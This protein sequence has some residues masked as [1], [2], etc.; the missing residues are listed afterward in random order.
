VNYGSDQHFS[1]APN[2]GYHVDS[3]IVDGVKV[4]SDTQYTFTNVTAAHTIRVTFAINT[5]TITSSAGLNGA[6]SPT[7][8]VNV[9]YGSDQHFSIAP[10]TGYH[11]D[12]LIVDG[13]KVTSDT[14]YTFTNVTAVNTIRVT[15]AINTF[16]ITSSAGANG[17]I[18]PTP[19][20][21]VNFGGSQHFSIAPNTGYHVDSLIVDG[22]KIAPD[23][24]YTFTNVTVSHTIRATFAINTFTIA[25][26]AGLNG[27]IL[28]TPSATVIYGLSQHFS[29]A[30]NT[31]YHM[32]SLI[33]DGVKVTSDTGYT[34]TNVTAVHT[35]RVTFAINTFIIT[36]SAGANG[37]ISPT[38]SATVNYGSD[39]HFSITPNTGYH[40][41]SLIMDGTKIASDT[42]YTFTNVTAAHTIR[43]AFV[44]DTF[45]IAS[46]AG[47]NGSISPTPSIR[48]TYGATQ[49]FSIAP[50]TG[51]HVDSLIIDGTPIAADTQYT[52]SS[53]AANHSIHA[54]F[55]INQFT[56]TATS[57]ANGVISPSGAVI[58]NYNLSQHFS[59][60]PN[61]GYHIDSLIVDGVN[62]N[63]DT[64]YT[65]KNVTASHTIRVTFAINTYTVT[66]TVT[67]GGT[68][69][70]S[71]TVSIA[72][73]ASQTF[74]FAANTGYYIV[75]VLYDG[76]SQGPLD[77]LKLTN[78]TAN[79][80]IHAAFAINQFTITA[81][82]AANGVISP[83]G[84]VIVNYNLSQHFS[85]V[86]NTGY[87][88][89]SLIID[90]TPVAADTQYTF[91]SVQTNHTIHAAF[92]INQFTI[93]AAAG[94]NGVVSPA[95]AVIVN[96]NLSQHFSIAP[97]TGY[98]VDS[99]IVDGV[100]ITSDTQYTF[101]NVNASH[102]IRVTFA[103]NTYSI[104][105]SAGANGTIS[106]TPSVTV[107]YGGSQHF[108]IA[109]NTG[110]HVD[111]LIVNGGKI[112]SDTQYTFTNVT[113]PHAIRATFA[114]NTFTIT[115]SAGADGT[116]SPTPSVIVNY[117]GS[118]HFSIV[119]NT[120]YHVDSLIVD[121]VKV[122][123]DTQYTFNSVISNHTINVVFAIDFNLLTPI[124]LAPPNGSTDQPVSPTLTWNT[125]RL[126][127][128]Y[129]LQVATDTGFTQRVIPDDT[130]LTD[131]F[132]NVTGLLNST[133]Y[134]WRVRA[135]HVGGWSD[136]SAR[137]DFSTI[138]A[139]PGAPSLL[140]PTN[141]AVN[142]PVSPT[143]I[144]NAA[145]TAIVYY[146]QLATD[147]GFTQRVIPDD[148]TL[149]DTFK[150]VSGLLNNT[151]YYWR[152]RAK[153]IGGWSNWSNRWGFTTIIAAPLAPIL[154]TPPNGSANQPVSPTLFWNTSNTAAN[155]DLQ[156]ATDAGF[157]QR[158]IPDDTTLT[159]T[160]KSISGL[161]NS[162]QYYW[163]VR[164]KNIGGWSN[165]SDTWSF[166]TIIAA[167]GAPLLVAPANSA[168]NQPTSAMFQWNHSSTALSY[169]LQVATDTGFTQRVI[170]DDTTLT[171]TLKSVDGL[172]NSTTY[173]WRV[174]AK[175]I[176][177]WSNWSNRWSFTTI[178][179]A[180][181]VPVL[182]APLSNSVNQPTSMTF[183][184]NILAT[185]LSYDLQVATDTGFTLKVIPDDTTLADTFRNVT[186]LLNSTQYYWRVR[187][188]NIGGWSG[189]S[190]RWSFTTIIAAPIAPVLAA[191]SNGSTNLPVPPVFSWNISNNATNYDLQ[192]AT[193]TGFTQRVIPD[194]TTLTDS[195]KNVAGLLNSTTYYWRVR[196]KNVGGWSG[197]SNRWSFTTIIAEPIAPVLAAPLNGSTNQ[198]VSPALFWNI[199]ATATNYDLQLA[200][201]TGFT[202]KVIP[203]DTTLTD[204][205][206]NVTGLLNST[207]YYWRVRAKN[208]GGWSSWSAR[209]S[210]TTII[211]APLAP[212][213]ASPLNGSANQPVSP[214]L[215]WNISNTAT[216]YDLQLATDTGFTQRVIPDDTTLT[217]T[218]KNVAGLLN[219]TT[220]YW[221]VRAKNAGGWSGW[222]NRWSFTTIIAA[223][224]A[225]VLV[226]P[227]N[228]SSNEPV[229]SALFWNTSN[230]ATNYDLQVA[231]DTG[232][233]QKVI[234]DDTTLADTFKNVTGLLNST[235]YYWRV[236]AKN[237]G[238]WSNW[239]NTWSFTTIIAAP[240][241]PLLAAP[242][243]GSADQP[244]SPT[245]SWNISNTA[246][247][248]ELQAA[249][250]T[251]F[252]QK[253]ISDDTTLTDTFKNIA[254][255]LNSTTYYWRVRAKNV[256]GWSGWSNRWSFTTVIA[257]PAAP[258]LLAP[259][260]GSVSWPVSP[261][262]IWNASKTT[263]AYYYQLATD[264]G[265]TQRVIPDDT[266]LTDTFKNVAGLLNNTTYYWRV[267]A[268][269]I[270]GWSNWSGRWGFTT[271]IV[272]PIAPAL[273][274]PANG[275][276]N[277]PVS[278]ELFWIIS[279]T[280]TNYDLQIATDT[281]FTQRVVPDDTTLTDTVKNITGLLNS[282][283]YYWRVR[284][285]NIGGWSN[286]SERWSF[287]TVVGAPAPP[288]L[289]VPSNNSTDQPTSIA[290]TWKHSA[291]SLS[292]ELQVATDT[293][294]TQKVIPDDTTLVDTVKNV[295]GL[296]NNTTYH[297]RVRSKNLG[298]WSNWSERWSFTTIVAAP[299]V[300]VLAA[301]L[302]NS[303]N[304]PTS[305]SL[306]W[307]VLST[308]LSYDLQLATDTGFTQKVI[309]DD[310]TLT[311]TFKNV[312]GLLNS[313]QYYWRV[314]AKNVGG[315]S[316]W[317]NRWSFT[318]IIAV[319]ITPVLAAPLNGSTNQP[320]SPRLAWNTSSTATNY[321]LQVAT[322][323]GF[324]Q[325]VIPDDTT[326]T[327][328]FKNISGLL[329][330]T[331]Y[332]WRVRAK[333]VGGWSNWSNRWSFTTI[334]AAPTSPVLAAPLNGSTNQPL[335]PVLFWN[336]SNTAAN[337]DL[338][339]AAD[340]GF[341]QKVIPDDTTLTDTFKNVTGLL[342]ST[343]Y[344]WR[345]RAKNVGGWSNWSNRWSF[346]TIIA[347]PIAPLLVTPANGATNQ[348]VSPALLWNT[349]GTAANYDLQVATDTGF[350]Q[351]VIPDDTTLTDTFKNVTGLLNSTT[352]Y[353]RVRAKNV[354]GWSN[355]SNRWSFATIITAPIA[356]LLVTPANGA[357][358]QPVSPILFWNTSI[359][360]TNYDLQ[361][362]ADTGFVQKVIP[363]DTTLTDTS[364]F[365]VGLL[366]NSTYYWR[367]RAKTIGGW[368]GWSSRWSF[369]TIIAPPIAPLLVTPAN[370]ATNEPVSLTLFWNTSGT[371][372]NY[373]L[374]LATDTGFTQKVI[375]D[376]TTLTDTFKNVNGLLN[377]TT[378]YWR[379]R[380]K[381]VGGW[382]NWSNRR[383]FTTIMT[384]PIAPV[385]A[386]PLNGAINQPVS[387]VVLWNTSNSATNYDL[388]LA[389]DTG[390]TQR[391][392]PDDTTLTDTVKNVTGLLNS[393]T[394]YWRVRAKNAGGWSNWSARWSFT[395]IIAAPIAPILVTP[396][397]GSTNQPVS[398]MLFWNTSSMATNYDLQIATDTGF[399]QR[400]VPDDTTLTDTFKN[401][402]GLL[403]STTYYWRV[404]AKNAGGWSNWSAR[405]SF[406]T[407]I[408]VPPTSVLITP[409]TNSIDQ[410]TSMIFQWNHAFS[411]L[412][413]D[414]Q[415]ATDTGF[416]QKVIPDDTTLADTVKSVDGLLNNTTYYWRVR[417]KNAG[418]WSNWSARWSFTT[419]IAAP[420]VP[421]LVAPLSNS[422]NQPTS[423][424]FRWNI[425]ATAL[426][427]DLQVATDT[428]FTQKVIPDDTTLTDTFKNISGLLNSTQ[429]YWRVRAKNIGGWSGWSNRWSFT[430]II[431][432]PAAPIL[433]TPLNGSP[434][435]TLSPAL[436]WNTSATATNYELQAA[437][438]T[439]FTQKV[440][441]DDTTLTDTSKS[442]TGLL[443]GTTY[444][445][446][447]RAKN[448]GGWSNWSTRWSF[449]T[450]IAAPA[451][452]I[453]VTPLNGSTN[454]PV[455]PTLFW[456][457]SSI[458][459]NYDLQ[460]AT[461]TGFTQR[462]IPDDTTLADTFKNIAGLL[463]STTYYWRVRA[464]NAGGWSD[465]SARW[466]FTTIIAVPTVPVL[467]APLNNSVD[468]PASITFKWNIL[469]TALSYDLQVATD[470][471]FTQK[472]ITDDTTLA[473]TFKNVSGLFNS[474][475]YYWRVRAKNAG[476][477][478]N[479]SNR[480]SFTTIIAAPAAPIL[481]APLNGSLN[482]P[483]SPALIWNTTSTATNYE[484]QA[485]TDTGF[486]QKIIP[487]DTTLTDT[488][489]NVTGLLNSTQ[490]YWRVRAKNIGGW[491]NWSA[492]W[493]FAT[494]I[495][496]PIAPLLMLPPNGSVNQ[497]VSP[498]LFWNTASTATNYDL[499]V[500]TDTGFAQKVVPDDTTMTDTFKN[501]TGLLNSTTYYWRV[502]SKNI[503]GWSGWSTVWNFTTI[504]AAPAAPLLV[505]P[506]NGSLNEPVSPVL[507]WNTSNT[508]T[509]YDLQVATDPGFAQKIIPDDTSLTDTFK[510]VTGLLNSTQYYWR[511]RAKN[512]GGW[513]GWSSVWSF[514]TIIAA[515][516]APVLVTPLNVSVNQP[517]SP[518]LFWNISNTAT[519]YDLQI[520]TDTGFTQRVIPDDT[521][522]TDTFKNVTGLLN[523][524]T[525]YWRVRAK[526]I[527][528][529]SNWT[530][531]WSFTTIIAAPSVPLLIEPANAAVNQPSSSI[532]RWSR[533]ETAVFYHLQIATD[534]GFTQTV[535][536][537]DTTYADTVENIDGLANNTLYY[538]RV[539]AKNIGG[540]SS[541]SNRSSFTTIIAAPTVPVLISPVSNSINQPLD[542]VLTW[543]SLFSTT[544]YELQVATDTGF[545][546]MI[547]PVD[548][549]LT[550]TVKSIGGLLNST[551]YYWRVRAKNI[552]G[553]SN[554]SNRWSFKTIIA[555]PSAPVLA[556]PS[557]GLNEQSLALKL[558]WNTSARAAD[559]LL[560]VATD[561]SFTQKAIPDDTTLTDT[562]KNVSGLSTSTMYYWRVR[563]RN[564][565]GWSDWSDVW[566]FTTITPRL[567][568]TKSV[569]RDTIL[570]GDTLSYT[571]RFK[572]IGKIDF[573][574]FAVVDTLPPDFINIQASSNA[575]VNGLVVHYVPQSLSA[576]GEDSI[577]IIATVP[578][579]GLVSETIVNKVTATSNE[580]GPQIAQAVS[581][582]KIIKH[583]VL[584]FSLATSK[585]TVVAGDTLRYAIRFGNSGNINL[586]NVVIADNIPSQFAILGITGGNDTLKSNPV[587]YTIDSLRLGQKDSIVILVR[588][589][590]NLPNRMR[591]ADTASAF[592]AETQNARVE[593][594]TI[595]KV[596]VPN[597][598]CRMIVQS[599]SNKVVGNGTASAVITVAVEDTLGT[600]KPDGT[601]VLLSTTLG[602]FSNGK[603]TINLP[604][605]GGFVKDSLKVMLRAN[606]ID[607]A[608]ITISS[609][610]SDVCYTSYVEHVIFFPGAIYGVVTDN[611]TGHAVRGASVR[612][613]SST[614]ALIDSITT[615]DDGS[616]M[617]P[618]PRTDDYQVTVKTTNIFGQII[619]EV[620]SIHVD[621]PDIG[622]AQP[623]PNDNSISGTLFSSILNV[624]IPAS[625]AEVIL[626]K[627]VGKSPGSIADSTMADS[628][629]RY[630]FRHIEP[631]N[632]TLQLHHPY[633]QGNLSVQN[634]RTGQTVTG[635]DI[636]CTWL[637][638]LQFTING[639]NLAF[640]TDTVGFTIAIQ[641]NAQ[642]NLTNV[643]VVDTLDPMMVFVSASDNGIYDAA[644]HRILWNFNSVDSLNQKNLLVQVSFVNTI[645]GAALVRSR[646]TVR[647]DQSSP[648]SVK[649]TTEVW[650][651]T[652]PEL[653]VP[654][655]NAVGQA[656]HVLFGW[657]AS[658]GATKYHLKIMQNSGAV[659][660][661]D[662]TITATSVSVDLDSP[663]VYQWWV[664]A[665]NSFGEGHPSQTYTFS[666]GKATLRMQSPIV[667]PAT[668]ELTTD[669]RLFSMPGLVDGIK[670][671]SVLSGSAGMDWR[672]F[673]DNGADAN[674]FVQLG[675]NST[676]AHGEG[677][678]L[679]KDGNLDL[680]IATLMPALD[681]DG[682]YSIPLHSGWNI[683]GNPYEKPALW[684]DILQANSL[685]PNTKLFMYVG[686][687]EDTTTVL[688]PFTGYY[689]SNDL[690]LSALTIPYP[691]TPLVVR[692]S[693]QK[694]DWKI[695]LL[696]QSKLNK[697][698]A[699][700]IGIAPDMSSPNGTINSRKPP[701]FPDQGMLYFNGID[702]AGKSRKYSTDFRPS[703]DEGQVWNFE[704]VN[705]QLS[706]SKI[707]FKGLDQVPAEYSVV[708]VNMLN[709]KPIDLRTAPAYAYKTVAAKM[710]FALI[711]GKPSFVEKEL[712][713][714]SPKEFSLA[715]NYPNPFNPATSISFSLP[716]K[717]AVKMEIIDILG[718]R[719][720][721]L[722]EGSY[723]AG[724]YTVVWDG[725]NASGKQASSGVYFYRMLVDNQMLQTRKMILLK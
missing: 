82:A 591:I 361:I 344:Y 693:T 258:S 272:P 652:F 330:S 30:P 68:I 725:K 137:W 111:S 15:F 420:S 19:S 61:T 497:P 391:V 477:W 265:F 448:A 684:S 116:I 666:V 685:N 112:T 62:I 576:G 51:Y 76:N 579:T 544:S 42:Q 682:N 468:Q 97:I 218:F 606:A 269:N 695:Q 191:P 648:I 715:Q 52:F 371:A 16:I 716:R 166:T 281:G 588:V 372:T 175:N 665:R 263:I 357:T 460:L 454:Q 260:N 181:S 458:A 109:A 332:Y 188:K 615:G 409:L 94:A 236:R 578:V 595:I 301:P 3:L 545:V 252:T 673:R 8:G 594:A 110:Y 462:V 538:W 40:V 153:N 655:N 223:P 389:T 279:S 690:N 9:N 333:N 308:A 620:S 81:T 17:T 621:I 163:R 498:A 509:N 487:D 526:N 407:I 274:T 442:I 625:S 119:P 589:P 467:S 556:A 241:A 599:S 519:N 493:S 310:T 325:R 723:E 575:Q 326:L 478:S 206:K 127:V 312:A 572:N 264:T 491:S 284:A 169:Y 574:N 524:T 378:Y 143:F 7:P 469:A 327:D 616:Y 240:A 226:A 713:K 56:I 571:I 403:N 654:A 552:G 300:P 431:A 287:T 668:A 548:T 149:T 254:G 379:V 118:Q 83:S 614:G 253:V 584:D 686:Q 237:I 324:T 696:F 164:A 340:T 587:V 640:S 373:D 305:V 268:K 27:T 276:T 393:T 505:T 667:F 635:A 228:G 146:F 99:L 624:P 194:D 413:Y 609:R 12:S 660:F 633:L 90:G 172:L 675:E 341:T 466:S 523:S 57:G 367:V 443:N 294:F 95:G 266:T 566:S 645:E 632:Y 328:T 349:S 313:T 501:V 11:V 600:P 283:Q 144:W 293:G 374:Q 87:H 430:T 464:K 355:W 25:S 646:A 351:R 598:S 231:T 189:W 613:A 155:Y 642:I 671:G 277:Q 386:S 664:Y 85:I 608:S 676:F 456:N 142:E 73:G 517:V 32:D 202:Q 124:L 339:V 66:T 238:G 71:G 510:N 453:L 656:N 503:G 573:T 55:A 428:G 722:A 563:A 457:I 79:H 48:L 692:Q 694:I 397:N 429:Y 365:V 593:L 150:N 292:Y 261:T 388:Q 179:A 18:S 232:F 643:A 350:T 596:V 138:I 320:V 198:I 158:V 174:R 554:W 562:F 539:R 546:H 488:F 317:S 637:T 74:K 401:V 677:Y 518:V 314:R 718:Q 80:T 402:T 499:Q 352:Y 216:N 459:T 484:L 255:L 581:Q 140:A 569:S 529:W 2:T 597:N 513:S 688:V 113:A 708:L 395:T 721:L 78:V 703:L 631:G 354:G 471:G 251:G 54:A 603:D 473:D 217:D 92:A 24:Q 86:P 262:F 490:Y 102:T 210:F 59:I 720:A 483:L 171:D 630:A 711:V 433:V 26:S 21:T 315:W 364:K 681:V 307:N 604:L 434:N 347:P 323:T 567:L 106:P 214:T 382:S 288:V 419:I 399:V 5:F 623:V 139:V 440:I 248:Y 369:T 120:G 534:T 680:T 485:A 363:D 60:A 532:F 128:T 387:P 338:Q 542:L 168:A 70:P 649:M 580:L 183:R 659:V 417:A 136:W 714:L 133:T 242:L 75:D 636:A 88:V 400:V 334:I 132:K 555:A 131:T 712:A 535:I 657:K 311:D 641:N 39:Q 346:T 33:V 436:F 100:K 551:T 31:G 709:S 410:P 229:T 662:S 22:T 34:F 590:N 383:S 710:R 494:I 282:T 47:A 380:A 230:T 244:V 225:P 416:T 329:N 437:T 618:V 91:N 683:I 190:N 482:Q 318:T 298:G 135:K 689:F 46:S 560:Q 531:R 63:S 370:G 6:I 697:D 122:T 536:P 358:N 639:P 356:P 77:S 521:T 239:S 286:W 343:Q 610:D 58:V 115:S 289:A 170:P 4:T 381:N 452:P 207:T 475:T 375:P 296:L 701:A 291:A 461:D 35:I 37:T 669:F 348:S 213:L 117:G 84:A 101:T 98:H 421:V 219:S 423:M 43:A 212:A 41:D 368:S 699:N 644:N 435:Q 607:T 447:V 126:A 331:T 64:Q 500:A 550:D 687:F 414:L 612:V 176:G 540:W 385:L 396:L 1:I 246:A 559:Y 561:T 508:A 208:L 267:R 129:Q 582:A 568:L 105:S 29:I 651:L 200:T 36:S 243:N 256:G 634:I 197:W 650:L 404:R 507:Y 159:D 455:S 705:S 691:V 450:I 321:D 123:S 49:H 377:S 335:S 527:G 516:A 617:I 195:F 512:I 72:Y 647:S 394:Y 184:W 439:S 299:S 156:V 45:T 224:L 543:G 178:I 481:A 162:T 672:A 177:G 69:T 114:I 319:P 537:D 528:G 235:T 408:A 93:T 104:T 585:D 247:N 719:V 486:T 336:T 422:V 405:W 306:K 297:W 592:S 495:A 107:N 337:Y 412:S 353:W 205:F 366:N 406:S 227:A 141:G 706:D 451:A 342:N 470:T 359:T 53:V 411:A 165:W 203:D 605:T 502:R 547:I 674:Y 717:S 558:V 211:A 415:V 89:D 186:G 362:A 295:D 678:W 602:S 704:V 476:G 515:P 130:T 273:V 557:N 702:K 275:S 445:W 663:N 180:P 577:R 426:S 525:Y 553:W 245:L 474:T 570:F 309:P 96:Y 511:V 250:D 480:W 472:V 479:W 199:S 463:N 520:A 496:A 658:K 345:V 302:S 628:I 192:V 700:Y 285:K 121:G 234:P 360:A 38:P 201:D 424:I 303:V 316:N 619:R 221:R 28:P 638:N 670:F 23:T 108:S 427:Y 151:V 522:L 398:P 653:S 418:G 182:V 465:W 661:D 50:N 438:D 10:N 13:V 196:A 506:A 583:P 204:T 152:V 622:G 125:A 530:A 304:Q 446:R 157:T 376:D 392:I 67:G 390:F 564:I 134:Y 514:K 441:P 193:D 280:A 167:P 148:T 209:W 161:L 270:G 504:I 549:S 220:Y 259:A 679:V 103:I 384:T 20:V 290:F 601:P 611:K 432:A 145:S 565:G 65:F 160:F 707:Q 449:T 541:W 627:E 425:L 444:Y 173:Y 271:I 278:P 215:F 154:I 489:K 322:D 147:T 533:S 724:F 222:S 185:A 14:Q 233:A 586:H 44:I 492:R 257:P 626:I 698:E 249:T 187:A 629:G